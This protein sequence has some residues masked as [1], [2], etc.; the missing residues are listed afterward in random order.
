MLLF[1]AAAPVLF[2]DLPRKLLIFTAL[3][4]F[5]A[6]W[7]IWGGT[8]LVPIFA[9]VGFVVGYRGLSALRESA[10]LPLGF[11]GGVAAAIVDLGHRRLMLSRHGA[12]GDCHAVAVQP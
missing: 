3:Y 2:F 8:I 1:V 5:I 10:A 7:L 4:P 9:L 11:F 12:L 6:F